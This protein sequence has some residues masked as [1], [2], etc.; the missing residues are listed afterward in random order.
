[1]LPT[2]DYLYGL[3]RGVEHVIDLQSG[4][5]LYLGLEAIGEPDERGLRTVV[6]TLN[7]QLRPLQIRDRTVDVDVPVA[8]R[9]DPGNPDARRGAVRRGRDAGRGRGRRRC[10]RGR[11]SRPSRR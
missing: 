2:V 5:Q 6:T 8:E 11:P 4:V 1:M 9:A 10:R 7:G 3:R